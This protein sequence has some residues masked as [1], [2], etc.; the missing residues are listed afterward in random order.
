VFGPFAGCAGAKSGTALSSPPI[1][2]T[3][4]EAQAVLYA[5]MRDL[6]A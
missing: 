3:G 1:V 6:A 2:R 4:F 5:V